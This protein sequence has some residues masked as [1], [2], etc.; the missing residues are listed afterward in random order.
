MRIDRV[1]DLS[2]PVALIAESES[3]NFEAIS[4]HCTIGTD[5]LTGDGQAHASYAATAHFEFI[6][7]RHVSFAGARGRVYYW[8]CTR[9]VASIPPPRSLVSVLLYQVRNAVVDNKIL[10]FVETCAFCAYTDV[11]TAALR[12]P[13]QL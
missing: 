12:C 13:K 10:R 9:D 8:L 11:V 1:G 7:F 4:I 6:F 3:E 2:Q 5:G